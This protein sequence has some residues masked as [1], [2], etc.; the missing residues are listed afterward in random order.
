[1]AILEIRGLTMR[2]GGITAVNRVDLTVSSGAIYSVIGP[3]GAGKTT[4][5][6][7]ITGIYEPTEGQIAFEGQP[8]SAPFRLRTAAAAAAVGIVTAFL[9]AAIAIDIDSLWK[10][11]I[12]DNYRDPRQPFSWAQATTSARS[13]IASRSGRAAFGFAVGLVIG[14]AGTLVSWRRTRRSPDVIT[15]RGIARTF[16]NIRLF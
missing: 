6:N 12:K 3:N 2:F 11:A 14:A 4:A 8:L 10:A 5:F 7:A 15:R 1:M 9:L 13:Y 16:Q